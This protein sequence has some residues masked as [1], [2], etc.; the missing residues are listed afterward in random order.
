[1]PGPK[2]GSADRPHSVGTAVPL[3]AGSE[4]TPPRPPER[5]LVAA[6]AEAPEE[7]LGLAVPA[8]M[9]RTA[10]ADRTMPGSY[11]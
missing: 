3:A 8:R 4:R 10:A 2:L 9:P 6:L 5:P 1:M 11:S 7:A